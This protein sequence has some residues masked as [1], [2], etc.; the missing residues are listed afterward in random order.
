M[1]IAVLASGSKGNCT[2]VETLKTK[3]LIDAGMTNLYIETKLKSLGI[4]PDDIENIFI[5]HDHVDH[6]SA[7]KVFVKR[8]NVKVFLTQKLYDELSKTINFTNYEILEGKVY[9]SDTIVTY[10]KTS[11]DAVDSVGYVFESDGKDFVYVTDTGY[12][13]NKYFDLLKNRCA[14]VFESN[15]DVTRLMENPNYP[16]NTKQRILSDKG[17][18]SNKDSAYYLSNFVGN[19][20]KTIILAHL[21]E[22]NNTKELALE[23]ISKRISNVNINIANQNEPT[24]L[25]TL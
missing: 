8:H 9:L 7:L 15:H 5:T 1:K 6:V 3:S 25:V 19:K 10:F 12:I 17:H 4:N 2:Y 24:E 21:S 11:H 14:Y 13:N 22:Q 20:T 18:L 23:E 16:Y